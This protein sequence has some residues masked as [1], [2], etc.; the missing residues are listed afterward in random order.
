MITKNFSLTELTRSETASKLKI[1]NT[2]TPDAKAYLIELAMFILQPLRDAY[3]KPIK[4]SS[5]YR[6]MKLNDAVKGTKTSQHLVGQAAD[7][8][9]GVEGNRELFNL[10]KKM[11]SEG[12]ISVGQLIDEKKY[13]WIH[14]SLPT[15]KHF[16][17]IL[18]L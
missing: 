4:I 18:H 6:C 7:I 5:G 14:I 11:I 13:S 17:E 15:A 1:D 16:N 10:A 2:P 9:I 12:K 8:N 3:G